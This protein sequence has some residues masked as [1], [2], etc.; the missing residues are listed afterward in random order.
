MTRNRVLKPAIPFA[1]LY[2]SDSFTVTTVAQNLTLDHS[3]YVTSHFTVNLGSGRIIF[4]RGNASGIF[5]IFA[6]ISAIKA[7][8]N[9]SY[10]AIVLYKNGVACPCSTSYG[11]VGA[12]NDNSTAVMIACTELYPEDYLEF[13]VQVDDGTA[14]IIDSAC[15]VMVEG[16]PM[17][18]WDNNKAGTKRF[19]GEV[20]R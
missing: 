10:I 3:C 7:S 1:E 12:G 2:G 5:R 4:N 17:F 9:P 18:G 11:F 19:I 8:G 20:I 6:S 14:T 15:R 16:L 13:K